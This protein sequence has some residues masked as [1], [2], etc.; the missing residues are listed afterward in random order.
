MIS[1]YSG[2]DLLSSLGHPA[3]V[4]GR[5]IPRREQIINILPGHDLK[6]VIYSNNGLDRYL[7]MG[8]SQ[9]SQQFLER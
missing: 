8:Y 6:N 9:G 3:T 1:S 2:A 4:S 7:L 5:W